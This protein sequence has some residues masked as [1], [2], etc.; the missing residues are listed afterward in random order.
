MGMTGLPP[1]KFSLSSPRT[2]KPAQVNF[3]TAIT[4]ISQGGENQ[5]VAYVLIKEHAIVPTAHELQQFLLLSLPAYMIPAILS[6]LHSLPIPGPID[7]KMRSFLA[8]L[9]PAY[10]LGPRHEF[11]LLNGFDDQ[12]LIG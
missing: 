10:R 5:L 4:R 6:R 3:A 1:G 2:K 11:G 9:H 7:R 12:L 8:A